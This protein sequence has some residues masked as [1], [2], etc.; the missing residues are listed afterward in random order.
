MKNLTLNEFNQNHE[1]AVEF[2]DANVEF[3]QILETLVFLKPFVSLVYVIFC[4]NFI[5]IDRQNG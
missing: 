3:R 1:V 4:M 5:V 2:K